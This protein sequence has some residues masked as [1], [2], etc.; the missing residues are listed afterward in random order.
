MSLR[1][2]Y[3]EPARP[4]GPAGPGWALVVVALV[5]VALLSAVLGLG[6]GR[7]TAPKAAQPAGKAPAP[8]SVQ[9]PGP[10]R[11]VNGVGVGYAHTKE[12]GIAAAREYLSVLGGPAVLDE[13]RWR[14]ALEALADPATMS[15]LA[16]DETRSQQGAEQYFSA[17]QTARAGRPVL[18]SA[19]VM[20]YKVD[21]FEPS[22]LKIE[23][24]TVGVVAV[25]GH[26]QL[27]AGWHIEVDQLIWRDGDWKLSV[28]QT[29]N[30][31]SVTPVNLGAPAGGSGPPPDLSGFT[32]V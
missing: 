30:T 32:S 11:V 14:P 12:G 19:T 3:A 2:A 28:A 27:A 21:S 18:L 24:Y 13:A 17:L 23:L 6:L 20:A 8:A 26:Q 5:M 15:Q 29:P 22:R 31:G 7:V 9:G 25:E 4:A 10:T 16:A 1:Q